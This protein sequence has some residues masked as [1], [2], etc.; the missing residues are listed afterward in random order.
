MSTNGKETNWNRK[1]ATT[2]RRKT[3]GKFI[4]FFSPLKKQLTAIAICEMCIF[5]LFVY[6]T[7]KHFEY[8]LEQPTCKTSNFFFLFSFIFTPALVN[9]YCVLSRAKRTINASSTFYR[10]DISG[11]TVDFMLCSCVNFE[12]TFLPMPSIHECQMFTYITVN[13]RR[14]R[15]NNNIRWKEE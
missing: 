13:E 15:N 11:I 4:V 5:M 12:N 7:N 9:I 6:H 2:A 3:F 10:K 14:S 8:Q 1:I